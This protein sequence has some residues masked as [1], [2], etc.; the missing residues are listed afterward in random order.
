M[1]R[2]RDL[3][4]TPGTGG[5]RPFTAVENRPWS[6]EQPV[7]YRRRAHQYYSCTAWR[8]VRS[9]CVTGRVRMG[10]APFGPSLDGLL[11]PERRKTG[12]MPAEAGGS[13]PWRQQ[14]VPGPWPLEGGCRAGCRRDR[15]SQAGQVELRH[16][17]TVDRLGGQDHQLPDWRVRCP[18]LAARPWPDRPRPKAWAEN[19]TR[20]NPLR[21]HRRQLSRFR[22]PILHPAGDQVCPRN[23]APP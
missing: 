1:D 20:R 9:P 12:W 19:P 2:G 22:H 17:A 21:P 11:G 5:F 15:L 3:T 7:R 13:G 18:S 4:A 10:D 23:L 16:G 14:A 6:P 8:L